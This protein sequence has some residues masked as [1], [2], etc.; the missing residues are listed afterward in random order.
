MDPEALLQRV[1]DAVSAMSP[2]EAIGDPFLDGLLTTIWP[3]PEERF[4][5]HHAI[6]SLTK[7]GSLPPFRIVTGS[8][9]W[10]TAIRKMIDRTSPA[11]TLLTERYGDEYIAAVADVE[12]ARGPGASIPY[13]LP[14]AAVT[15]RR[16]HPVGKFR[17]SDWGPHQRRTMPSSAD[18][19]VWATAFENARKEAEPAWKPA[20]R[21]GPTLL[22]A[23]DGTWAKADELLA[24]VLDALDR[25]IES[26]RARV[27]HGE[28][29]RLD[30]ANGI[31]AVIQVR[32]GLPE[33]EAV[34]A[35]FRVGWSASY[36]ELGLVLTE[37]L[38]THFAQSNDRRKYVGPTVPRP[39][40]LRGAG[41]AADISFR[42]SA[43]LGARGGVA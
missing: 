30:L 17:F 11:A 20:P 23:R 14:V 32:N 38:D 15:V 43:L 33:T 7:L 39:L 42:A 5:H 6:L 24:T 28:W 34:T 2:D 3:D 25:N 36:G 21:E 9:D 18:A 22:T 1:K 26:G 10:R 16:D 13:L 27:L 31:V 4:A 8:P 41:F 29:A 12:R 37:D 40:L 19:R 35:G